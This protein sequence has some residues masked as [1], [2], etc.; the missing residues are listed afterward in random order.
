MKIKGVIVI[1]TKSNVKKTNPNEPNLSRRS[2]WRSRNKPNLPKS[3]NTLTLSLLPSD[4]QRL[5]IREAKIIPNF[6]KDGNS[7]TYTSCRLFYRPNCLNG[8][9]VAVAF[10]L[11][12]GR[13]AEFLDLNLDKLFRLNL[14]EAG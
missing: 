2:L 11:A 6:G 14:L 5:T 13:F 10:N 4:D 8:L 1:S 7:P 12:G 9:D 3:G